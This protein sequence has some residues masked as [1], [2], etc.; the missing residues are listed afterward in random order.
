MSICRFA[1]DN[2]DVYVY[3]IGDGAYTC[4]GCTLTEAGFNGGVEATIRHLLDHLKAGHVVPDYA[5]NLLLEE[6]N[7]EDYTDMFTPSHCKKCGVLQCDELEHGR[8][9]LPTIVGGAVYTYC[10]QCHNKYDERKVQ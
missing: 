8:I 6:F 3:G 1:W 5:I 4:C 9:L 7:G 10:Q 2:S